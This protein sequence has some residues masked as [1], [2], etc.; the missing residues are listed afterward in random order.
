MLAHAAEG[1]C[2]DP[3]DRALL[4][5]PLYTTKL[6]GAGLGLALVDAVARAH[7]GSASVSAGSAGSGVGAV[8]RIRL[9]AAVT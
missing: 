2:S 5:D 3:L 4:F 8:F 6:K 1:C 7:G 9:G